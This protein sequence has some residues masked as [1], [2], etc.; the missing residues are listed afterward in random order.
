MFAAVVNKTFKD[1]TKTSKPIIKRNICEQNSK[2]VFAHHCRESIIP[3]FAIQYFEIV[4][5]NLITKSEV[6]R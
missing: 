1:M 2:P 5:A 6:L 3:G 4:V